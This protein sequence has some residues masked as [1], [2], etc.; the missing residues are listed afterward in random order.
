[1][2]FKQSKGVAWLLFLGAIGNIAFFVNA[3]THTKVTSTPSKT[4]VSFNAQPANCVT[5]RQ[6]R[7]CYAQVSLQWSTPVK[8]NF[9]I[10]AKNEHS[11]LKCWQNTN[12]EQVIFEFES[13]EK[14]VYLLTS[15]DDKKV[16]AKTSIDVSW[17]HNAAP[18]KRRWRLF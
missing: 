15:S 9:C 2:Y 13:G 6:G 1:M 3:E 11:P 10:Y 17:V 18:R 4:S 14:I 16:I 12:N 5:L 7:K 8:G